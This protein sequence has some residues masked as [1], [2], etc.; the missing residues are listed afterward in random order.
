[1]NKLS[2]T[3]ARCAKVEVVNKNDFSLIPVSNLFQPSPVVKEP[4]PMLDP[5]SQFGILPEGL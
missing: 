5:V 3:R 2:R 4:L 1:M